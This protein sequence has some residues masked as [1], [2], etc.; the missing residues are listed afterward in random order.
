MKVTKALT[1][2]KK[3]DKQISKL[4]QQG[5]FILTSTRGRTA[6]FTSTEEASSVAKSNL[7][8]IRDLMRRRA[9]IKAKVTASNAATVVT[10][11]GKEMTVAEAIERKASIEQDETLL[12]VMKQ[13][14]NKAVDAQ[15]KHEHMVQVEIDRKV[16]QVFGNVKK[17]G[18]NDA[19]YNSI[20][21]QVQKANKFELIDP[22]HLA[23][24]I[25][26][27]ETEIDDFKA[28]V[29]VELSVANA[30]TEIEID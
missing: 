3:L 26:A 24:T 12:R 14:F 19:T 13:Q 11:A 6:G 16:E 30:T 5:Q 4:T 20:Q 18:S 15:A 2:I 29:D 9:A 22:N 23:K 21:E 27:L 7:D 17:V 10:I 8:K 1:E 25:E 28:N